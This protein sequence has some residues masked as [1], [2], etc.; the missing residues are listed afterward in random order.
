MMIVTLFLHL[1]MD[2]CHF[3][4]KEKKSLQQNTSGC[5]F[6]GSK[7]VTLCIGSMKSFT[8]CHY[9]VGFRVYLGFI[10]M[11]RAWVPMWWILLQAH[12]PY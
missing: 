6:C 3:G 7:S 10:L 2:D 5:G 9:F 8:V 11:V 1:P 4:Y 12:A